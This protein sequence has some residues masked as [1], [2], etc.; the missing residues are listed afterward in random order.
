MTRV[1]YAKLHDAHAPVPR[2]W[3]KVGSAGAH[4]DQHAVLIERKGGKRRQG[5][6]EFAFHCQ[7]AD[8]LTAVIRT[9][10]GVF[11]TTFPAGGGGKIRGAQ[12]K[13]M[14]LKA[15]MPD[16][17]V[18][19]PGLAIGIEI[20]TPKNYLDPVQRE[21][22]AALKAAGVVCYTA[23]STQ[24]VSLILRVNRLLPQMREAA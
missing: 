13:G 14:G 18:F 22:H 11:W 3:R 16:I 9:D 8:F 15:G 17:L 5:T 7:V 12:L 21:T 20:K 10:Q 4:R 6:S 24:D 23:K 1:T 19:A 2:G